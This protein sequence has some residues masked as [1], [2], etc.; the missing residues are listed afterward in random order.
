[1]STSTTKVV[2]AIFELQCAIKLYHWKTQR[3][4]RHAAADKLYEDILKL[5]DQMVETMI[6]RYGRPD[7]IKTI[8][9]PSWNDNEAVDYLQKNATLFWA[10][11]FNKLVKQ[12]DS[13]LYSIRDEILGSINQT[14][15]LMSLQ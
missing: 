15:Y 6:A 11:E 5:G 7:N 13:D 2:K 12:K 10:T 1:M 3:F 4:A 14:I 8:Q 9:C